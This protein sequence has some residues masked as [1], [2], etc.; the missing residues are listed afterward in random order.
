MGVFARVKEACG[1]IKLENKGAVARDHLANERTFLAWLRTSLAFASIGVAITQFFR[2]QSSSNTKS[3][4]AATAQ[5][6]SAA[7]VDS[8][9]AVF[10]A[11]EL[12]TY[13]EHVAVQEE[14]LKRFSTALGGFFIAAGIV[15][16]LLGLWRYFLSQHYLQSGKFPASRISI[17]V[18]FLVTFT[19]STNLQQSKK[20]C[21][22][23]L[24][25]S[26]LQVL[27]PFCTLKLECFPFPCTLI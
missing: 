9:S 19:V 2:L 15:I 13:L 12:Y 22:T 27:S 10:A 18:T 14:K 16:I 20:T 23:T 6:N 5:W 25:S 1:S 8:A 7:G 11:P 24:S 21:L 26:S 3:L 4:V 17:S